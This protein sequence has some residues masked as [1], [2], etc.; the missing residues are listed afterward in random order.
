[1]AMKKSTNL[2]IS[3]SLIIVS[4]LMMTIFKESLNKIDEEVFDFLAPLILGFGLG[5]GIKYIFP[6]KK[7]VDK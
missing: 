3:I 6:K 2:I 1:M 7:K 4:V 5:R